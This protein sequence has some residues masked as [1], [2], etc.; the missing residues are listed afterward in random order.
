MNVPVV[1]R[2]RS[3]GHSQQRSFSA[4]APTQARRTGSSRNASVVF[5]KNV[6][7]CRHGNP[8]FVCRGERAVVA[9]R[10][11]QRVLLAVKRQSNVSFVVLSAPEVAGNGKDGIVFHDNR[12]VGVSVCRVH[13][14]KRSYS[15]VGDYFGIPG[16]NQMRLGRVGRVAM[17]RQMEGVGF[18]RG[19]VLHD[20]IINAVLTP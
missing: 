6:G 11:F 12:C 20:N 4:S 7:F 10:H 2:K 3:A 15:A 16:H 8:K 14:V 1:N 5:N 19:I 17:V 9:E 13:A 18:H